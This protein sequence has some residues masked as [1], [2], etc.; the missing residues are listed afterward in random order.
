[1][2][3]HQE[4]PQ[5]SLDTRLSRLQ[6]AG[7]SQRSGHEQV[8][9]ALEEEVRRDLVVLVEEMLEALPRI[10]LD[11]LRTRIK[12]I[13]RGWNS[14][15]QIRANLLRR[16][17]TTLGGQLLNKGKKMESEG[18]LLGQDF[19]RRLAEFAEVAVGMS[20][21]ELLI[22]REQRFWG[23]ALAAVPAKIESI[24]LGRRLTKTRYTI[25]QLV[26]ALSAGRELYREFVTGAHPHTV[27]ARQFIRLA[28]DVA[29]NKMPFAMRVE[30]YDGG[31]GGLNAF[32]KVD[33]YTLVELFQRPHS[34]FIAPD[35][36]EA[37]G[38]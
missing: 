8:L 25:T 3:N 12:E 22:E 4:A 35:A 21:E 27:S 28:D 13:N 23:I 1:M 18:P 11:V 36:E 9:T 29:A 38:Q 31:A 32:E 10:E 7:R 37:Q 15:E 16:L 5:K 14:R 26:A 20:D 34:W 6:E 24:P 17:I 19:G 33:H 30:Q 2:L